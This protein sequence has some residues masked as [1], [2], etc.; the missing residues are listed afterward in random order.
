MIETKHSIL[1]ITAKLNL[2][3]SLSIVF[4][5]SVYSAPQS[6]CIYISAFYRVHTIEEAKVVNPFNLRPEEMYPLLA[7]FFSQEHYQSAALKRVPILSADRSY[8]TKVHF[9]I[10]DRVIDVPMR[11]IYRVVYSS[12]DAVYIVSANPERT[13]FTFTHVS[14]SA[15]NLI[16]VIHELTLTGH[17]LLSDPM[18]AQSLQLW[19]T[20]QPILRTVFIKR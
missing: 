1:G 19:E 14:L 8:F 16:P 3:L 13:E 18:D 11:S 7:T 5:C 6:P 15:E 20:F 10:R 9:K 17:P 12:S 2:I 4:V